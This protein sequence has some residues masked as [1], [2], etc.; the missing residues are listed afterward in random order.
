MRIF[1]ASGA[2]ERPIHQADI[3]YG[4]AQTV[5]RIIHDPAATEEIMSQYLQAQDDYLDRK[6][7][8]DS[9]DSAAR[10][11][12]A[13]AKGHRMVATAALAHV[14]SLRVMHHSLEHDRV[15][16][17]MPTETCE[18]APH[19][20]ESCAID[21][22]SV[23]ARRVLDDAQ[24]G[25]YRGL[26]NHFSQSVERVHRS[27][28]GVAAYLPYELPSQEELLSHSASDVF[29]EDIMA[30]NVKETT[31]GYLLLRW[32]AQARLARGRPHPL[33]GYFRHRTIFCL[34]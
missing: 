9:F 7:A 4:P 19:V 29:A 27:L 28:P 30:T 12:H 25:P 15:S 32:I 11:E 2:E 16:P 31:M 20:F 3:H 22:V 10:K 17:N 13:S 26:R 14:A 1:N 24:E 21:T 6:Y 23:M 5:E 8:A 33:R 34:P 18:G